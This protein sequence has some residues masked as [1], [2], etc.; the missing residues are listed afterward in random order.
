[1]VFNKDA[2]K[3]RHFWMG[4][5]LVVATSASVVVMFRLPK[6]LSE[7][8]VSV[9]IV[10]TNV[11]PQAMKIEVSNRM[12]FNLTYWITDERAVNKY[13]GRYAG[14]IVNKSLGAG[15]SVL[16]SYSLAA[17]SQT[18]SL[19]RPTSPDGVS[20]Q[21]SY[22]RQLKPF[23]ISV[24]KTF[25]WLKRHYPFNRRRSLTIYEVKGPDK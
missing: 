11:C 10:D 18:T 14:P 20:L 22:E 8:F 6:R 25:P 15:S 4:V 13:L 24:L 2:P 1:M 3:A 5:L 12:S 23:E 19:F 9:S 21:L 7:P 17:H 16:N